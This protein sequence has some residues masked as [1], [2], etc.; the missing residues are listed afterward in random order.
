MHHDIIRKWIKTMTM[1]LI[2]TN[3]MAMD[4]AVNGFLT[5]AGGSVIDS[6]KNF[7]AYLD[8]ECP[9]FITDYNQGGVYEEGDGFTLLRESRIGL[10]GIAAITPDLSFTTQAVMRA[11]DQDITLEWAYLT[12]SFNDNWSANFGRK[13]LPIYFYSEFQDIGR[14]Y[15][16]VRP[17]QTLYGWE[18]SNFNGVNLN[19]QTAWDET[20]MNVS[21][22]GGEEE[23][24]D[25]EY[26]KIYDTVTQNSKWENIG[27]LTVE[28]N[29]DW[30]TTRFIYLQSDNYLTDND[31]VYPELDKY[32]ANPLQQVISGLAFNADFGNW[33]LL[34]EYN[35]NDREL[36]E[37]GLS[38]KATNYTLGAGWR[39]DEWTPFINYSSYWEKSGDESVYLPERY[40]DLSFTL[41]YDIDEMSDIKIQLDKLKDKSKF[42]FVGD[43]TV[44]SFAYD[45]VF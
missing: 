21:L 3:S 26:A 14:A 27:G 15:M 12:Y 19:Y 25:S 42:D 43:T 11:I 28:F 33:F 18:V 10:Q 31:G 7:P 23:V 45:L 8:Y 5:V 36:K 16:F 37:E 38:Y 22:F 24:K 44:I 13:R 41:R 6:E 32:G 35:L 34:S 30:L 1:V 17:P 29:Y 40:T 20:S 2:S 39:L 9:C 4:F